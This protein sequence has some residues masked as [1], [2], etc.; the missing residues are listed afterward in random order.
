MMKFL[1]LLALAAPIFAQDRELGIEDWD[2]SIDSVQDQGITITTDTGSGV[3][4]NLKILVYPDCRLTSDSRTLNGELYPNPSVTGIA[5]DSSAFTNGGLGMTSKPLTFT[6]DEGIDGNTDI[7]SRTNGQNTATVEFCIEVG[8]YDNS[9]LVNFAEA[10]LTYN[11]DLTT[12]FTELTGYTVTQADAFK[13]ATDVDFSFQGTLNANFCNYTTRAKL[14]DTG[15]ITTQ[16]SILNV[17]FDNVPGGQFEVHDVID[18]TVKEQTTGTIS[19]AV[20]SNYAIATTQTPYA[21][22][23]CTD[24]T[25]NCVVRLLLKA[26]FYDN[27]LLDLTGFGNVELELGN[28]ARRNLRALQAKKSSQSAEFMIQPQRFTIENP[29]HSSASGMTAFAALGVMAGAA[30]VIV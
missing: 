8:M 5:V 10:L 12:S 17:C 1:S 22:V 27:A 6:F 11:V 2:V 16:G 29:N 19:Q 18:L 13:N 26:E 3:G 4:K 28:T 23:E 30:L 14:T 24:A 9:T 21:V 20:V 15:S 25:N 7:Y